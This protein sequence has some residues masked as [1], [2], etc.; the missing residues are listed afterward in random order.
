M[1][2]SEVQVGVGVGRAT[3]GAVLLEDE[4]ETQE[5]GVQGKDMKL[6]K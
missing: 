1:G 3:R 6:S 2:I 4:K 5:M